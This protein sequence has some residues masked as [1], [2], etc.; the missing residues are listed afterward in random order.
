MNRLALALVIVS[1]ASGCIVHKWDD[2]PG[3]YGDPPVTDGTHPCYSHAECKAGCYCD[4]G[5]G[6]CRRAGT[7]LVD[8]DCPVQFRCDGRGSCIP[9]D[10]GRPTADAGAPEP[11]P[12]RRHPDAGAAPSPDATP[13][14]STPPPRDAG[15]PA[16][17]DAGAASGCTPR[18]RF[19]QQCAP[20][21]RC[22]DGSCQRPCAPGVGVGCGTGAVC[23]DGFCQPDDRPGGQCVYS[24]QCPASGTCISGT[25]HPGCDA[26]SDCPNHADV[27]DRGVC[28][29]DERPQPPCTASAQ[30]G[31]GNSCVDGLCRPSC[32]CEADC[33]AIWGMGATCQRGFCAAPGEAATP[34]P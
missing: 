17:C 10:A 13:I 21:A 12:P 26:D 23:K 2:D 11:T 24:S 28:R 1:S 22:L 33:T 5:P 8:A 31:G 30:C 29:P 20:G 4:I 18:C 3:G 19:T 25:C 32:T 6:I 16:S 9:R 14:S 27:C 15:A 7:C 34:V